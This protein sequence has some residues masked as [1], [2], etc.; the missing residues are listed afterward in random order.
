MTRQLHHFSLL[1]ALEC[2]VITDTYA[3]PSAGRHRYIGVSR[4]HQHFGTDMSPL[5]YLHWQVGTIVSPSARWHL[6]HSS[7]PGAGIAKYYDQA[8]RCAH[9]VCWLMALQ[10]AQAT[11]W[12][13]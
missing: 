8:Q 2:D 6:Y 3:L 12:K 4:Q 5:V 10:Q 9:E 7:H 13:S 11:S 1:V